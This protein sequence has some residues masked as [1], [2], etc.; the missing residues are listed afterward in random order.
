MANA[1]KC[2]RCG[3]LYEMY[4]GIPLIDEGNVYHALILVDQRYDDRKPFDL[5]PECMQKV[6]YFLDND[7]NTFLQC[8]DCKHWGT[9][10]DD[11]PCVRCK[12]V[13][14]ECDHD[15]FEYNEKKEG[16]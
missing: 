2:D 11:T 1:K 15:Y 4:R 3:K 12:R 14:P 10:I 5:C 13:K 6:I 8:R 9:R 16:E 7:G